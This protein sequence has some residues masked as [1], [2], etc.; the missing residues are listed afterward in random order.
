MKK[1]SAKQTK[2]K[3]KTTKTSV[4]TSGLKMKV[5]DLLGKEKESLTLPKELFSVEAHP[6]LIAQYIRVYLANQ[7]QG[8]AS[9]KTRSEVTGSTRKIYRQKGTGRARH[10]AKS[11]P[12]FVGG[13]VFAGP[14]PRDWSLKMNKKQKKRILFNA[15]TLKNKEGNLIGLTATSLKTEPKTKTIVKFLKNIDSDQKKTLLVLPK[16]E[17]NNLVL[18]AR[19]IKNVRLTDAK[20]I[21]PYILLN[22]QKVIMVADALSVIKE[23][24]LRK[25]EN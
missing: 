1:T 23:H 11:A 16:L 14:K 19:N 21:N 13:G 25:N 3:V 15:L 10:G 6:K 22:S 5:Y 7:R 12:I 8:T 20:S 2:T 24:F 18:A 17:K 4:S 9:T